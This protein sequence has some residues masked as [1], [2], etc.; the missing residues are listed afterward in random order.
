LLLKNA[1]YLDSDFN[2]AQGD[3]IIRDGKVFI[4]EDGYGELESMDC[5]DYIIIPGLY[6]AH[7]HGYSLTAKGI[8]KDMNIEEWGN[9]SSQG[10]V[11]QR[12]FENVDSL[13]KEEYQLLLTKAY[14]EMAKQGIVFASESEPGEW[15][16]AAAEAMNSVG[17]KGLVDAYGRIDEFHGK[18]AGKASFGTHLLEEEDIT[19]EALA[20]CETAKKKYDSLHLTH[21]M[22]NHWRKNLI[23][24]KYGKSSVELYKERDLLDGKTILFHGV[25]LNDGDIKTLAQ[26]GSSIVHCPVSNFWSGAGAAPVGTMLEEGVTVCLGTDFASVDIWET[27]KIAYFLLKNSAAAK[28]FTAEDIFKMASH[29]GAAAYHQPAH[30]SI[31]NG[32]AA[33]LVFIKK[34]PLIRDIETAGFSTVVHNLLM[35]T[36]AERIYHVMVDGK[37]VLFDRKITT[38]DEKEVNE[39]YERVL[40]KIYSGIAAENSGKQI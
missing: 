26:T 22:E 9:G 31:Q 40:E 11:Q 34:D 33:D 17:I 8:A 3:L 38:V 27:M 15:P 30:G 35:E 1:A 32:Y 4:E 5:T 39:E 25:H 19:E 21:C 37:W 20:V 24:E 28:Q 12:F 10:Q 16:D 6:N 36:Q 13:A 14:I 2:I 23:F 29:N 18:K 7:F